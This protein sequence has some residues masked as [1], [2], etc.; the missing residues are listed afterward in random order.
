MERER[1]VAWWA[2]CTLLMVQYAESA[3]GSALAIVFPVGGVISVESLESEEEMSRKKTLG[4]LLTELRRR[5]HVDSKL[6]DALA[7][8]LTARNNLVHRFTSMFNLAT[9][10]G[11]ADAIQFCKTLMGQADFVARILMGALFA[12]FRYIADATGA[13]V[14]PNWESLPESARRELGLGI[15]AARNMLRGWQGG[16]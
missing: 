8:F 4:G 10:E 2:G 6:D 5:A 11:E 12:Q 13:P 1:D 9:P 3:L 16:K 14:E 15:I 7:S